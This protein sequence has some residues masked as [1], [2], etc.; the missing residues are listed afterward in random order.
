MTMTATNGDNHIGIRLR[1]LRRDAR[2]TQAQLAEILGI[3]R[4]ALTHIELGAN[5]LQVRYIPQLIELFG[6]ENILSLFV[7]TTE[8]A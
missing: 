6:S 7:D 3:S 1:E 2:M 5:E 4:T 8:P